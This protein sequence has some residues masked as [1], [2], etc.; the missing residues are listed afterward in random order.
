M[1]VVDDV[2]RVDIH[3]REPLHHPFELAGHVIELEVITLHRLDCRPDLLAADF[4]SPAVDGV[5]KT[6]GEVSARSEELHLLADEHRRNTAGNR[7]I[8]TPGATHE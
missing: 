2:H 7:T 1:H 4:V 8:V 6:F 5:E 3:T